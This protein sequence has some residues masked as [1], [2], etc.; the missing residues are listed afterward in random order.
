[1]T[2]VEFDKKPYEDEDGVMAVD[3]DLNADHYGKIKFDK[4][5]DV[6]VLWPLSIDDAVSY[7]KDLEETE[8]TIHEELEA[9]EY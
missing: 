7:F 9:T 4:D 5:Q 8:N 3:V 1:M 6:W 2:K